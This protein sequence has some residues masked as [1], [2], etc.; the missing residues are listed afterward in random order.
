LTAAS[1]ERLLG[2]DF[3]AALGRVG[4]NPAELIQR[5]GGVVQYLDDHR[6]I[7]RSAQGLRLESSSAPL[8]VGG[9][10]RAKRPVELGLRRA[11]ASYVPRNPVT[12]LSI[13]D[14]SLGGAVLSTGVSLTFVGK[15]AEGRLLGAQ[16]VFFPEVAPS[17]DAVVTSQLTGADFA[18]VLRS[19]SAPQQIRYVVRL[20]A[21]S[22]LESDGLGAVV[23]SRANLVTTRILPP[24]SRDAQG[25]EIPT[26]LTVSGD[27]LL[28]TLHPRAQTYAYPILVDPEARTITESAEGWEFQPG[29]RCG[30]K[31]TAEVPGGGSPFTITAPTTT[32]PYFGTVACEEAEDEL[33]PKEGFPWQMGYLRWTPAASQP[34]NVAVYNINFSKSVSGEVLAEGEG[35]AL[36]IAIENTSNENCYYEYAAPIPYW[37][38]PETWT[39]SV[40]SN[41][42]C[43]EASDCFLQFNLTAGREKYT[44]ENTITVKA[45]VSAGPVVVSSPW[46]IP[47]E[48]ET[49]GEDWSK[50]AAPHVPKCNCGDPVDSLTGNESQTQMDLQ[51]G[52]RGPGLT[53]T[54]VYNSMLAASQGRILPADPGPTGYGWRMSYSAHMHVYPELGEATVSLDDGSTVDFTKLEEGSPWNPVGSLVQATLASSGENYVYTLP[55]Q[56]QLIFNGSGQLTSERD[57]NGNTVTISRNGEGLVSAATDDAGRKITFA[58]DA[59]GQLESATDPLGHTVT[60]GYEAGNL[61]S[62]TEPGEATPRWQFKYNAAHGITQET[63]GKGHSYSTEY[64]ASGRVSS[65]TD[66]LGR[67]R[68][69]SYFGKFGEDGEGAVIS[70][71]INEPNSAETVNEFNRSGLPL[72]ITRDAGTEEAS[73][74]YYSYDFDN[75]LVARTDPNGHK[76][77]FEYDSAGDKTG[78]TD[79]MGRT[80]HWEYDGRHDIVSVTEPSGEQ[81]TVERDG[82]GNATNISR[83]APESKTQ[84]T[85]YAYDEYGDLE[86]ETAPLE[87]TTHYAYDEYGDRESETDSEGNTRTWTYDK[88][89]REMSSVL[90][91]GNVEGGEPS[92]FTTTIE[93]DAQGRPVKVTE[94]EAG[95]VLEAGEGEA[96]GESPAYATLPSISG[97]AIEGRVLAA[98]AGT[99]E[100]DTPLAYT[101]QWQSCDS[102]GMSCLDIAGATIS[103]Y[104]PSAADVGQTLRVT[105]TA[106]NA[107]G[108]SSVSSAPTEPIDEGGVGWAYVSEFGSSGS[109]AGEFEHPGAIAADA[110][111]N[112]W[113]AD[114]Y[115]GRIEEFGAEGEFIKQFGSEGAEPGQFEFP[116]GIAADSE[117]DLWVL[118]TGNGRVQ[119]V[120]GEGEVLRTIGSFGFGTGQ[121]G[122]PEGI[123]LDGSGNVWVADTYHSRL[124]EF[125]GGGE[126]VKEIESSGTCAGDLVEP[127]G[128]AFDGSGNLWVADWSGHRLEELNASGECVAAIGGE[129]SPEVELENPYAVSIDP[130]GDVS[131]GSVEGDN[132]TE[133]SHE[134]AFLARF[135]VPGS[136]AG[137]LELGSP[138]GIAASASSVWVTDSAND[139][140]QLWRET[141]SPTELAAPRLSDEPLLGESA[142]ATVGRWLGAGPLSYTYQW[143]RCSEAGA[144]CSDLEGATSSTYTPSGGDVGSTLR[145]VV[146]ATNGSGSN[147]ANSAVSDVVGEPGAPS[148]TVAPT[149]AGELDVGRSLD[150]GAGSWAGAPAPSYTYQWRRCDAGGESCSNISGQTHA[151]YAVRHADIGSTLRVTVT[152]HNGLGS[153]A[154]ASSAT[155]VVP[156]PERSTLYRYDKNGNLEEATDPYGQATKYRYDEDNERTA[157]EE[158]DGSTSETEYGDLGLVTA[159]TNGGKY[160]TT[161]RHN[162]LG[163]VVETVD[164]LERAT[165]NT[166]DPAGNLETR[167][168]PAERVS[169][170]KYDADDELTSATYSDGTTPSVEYEYTTSGERSKMIDGTGTTTYGYDQ[171]G[172]LTSVEDG[173]GKTTEYGYD[174][175]NDMTK[176][177]YPNEKTVT[178]SF[179]S[180]GSLKSV[181]DWNEDTT[182]F[183][184]DPDS[185]LTTTTFPGETGDVDHYRYDDADLMAEVEMKKGSEVL[186]ATTYTRDENGLLT[187]TSSTGLPGEPEAVYRYNATGRMIKAGPGAYRYDAA[188]NLNK[189][190]GET[191]KYDAASELESG[192]GATYSY[193]DM[194]E[195]TESKPASGPAT[196]YEF[197]QAGNLITVKRAS[198]GEVSGIE[199]SFAYDG[200]GVRRTETIGGTSTDLTWNEAT[201]G[202]QLLSDG[203]DSFIYGPGGL[204][205]EQIDGEEHVLYLHHDEQGSTRLLTG[206]TGTVKGAN[207]FDPYGK[208]E[209]H[210]GSASTRLGYA[211]QY[212]DPDSGLIYLRARTYDPATAQFLSPDPLGNGIRE[213][214]AYGADDP[215]NEV[216]T[217]GRDAIPLP[218]EG[219]VAGP[220]AA[221]ACAAALTAGALLGREAVEN[222]YETASQAIFGGGETA[223]SDA[224]LECPL[225]RAVYEEREE[226]AAFAIVFAARDRNPSQDKKLSPGQLKKLKKAGYDPHHLKEGSHSDI[227]VGPDGQLYEKPIGG[228]GPG[229]DLGI[230][231]NEL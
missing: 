124:E 180:D 90:P 11:G 187:S 189:M 136:E 20:P 74:T 139:R 1:S 27:E 109:E 21:G 147:T 9:H 98:T 45:S 76:T 44:T 179:N 202:A 5:G 153:E 183:S 14:S 113:V 214:Y 91:R 97:S 117:G 227:Y 33:V 85:E 198:E 205:V 215:V 173:A 142:S 119:E 231:L 197:D 6:A 127:E 70:T 79:P 220:E 188:G 160:T 150:A 121:L 148:N 73:T 72:R 226:E 155:V 168:D 158:P 13:A 144:E 164:P 28:I 114:A 167:T 166:Y 54:R 122:F 63:D 105:V 165:V 216:D 169:T 221:A 192:A 195:R 62:V 163:E 78:E 67:K 15:A 96:G 213:A 191:L 207:T 29:E 110:S 143:Q 95:P 51:V 82:N 177:V 126:Y 156:A 66:P 48:S 30:P 123:A 190:D 209:A 182:S 152:A 36:C 31:F 26:D 42:T 185:D 103:S 94:P 10:G 132:V 131:V 224:A 23:L 8:R 60:Y 172:R 25:T 176:V 2:Q 38:P 222:A 199:D 50:L 204:P 146:T 64:D 128:L 59:E 112:L 129:G 52:G 106:K 141:A 159:Q 157:V 46:P 102:L 87:R 154:A 107:A 194:G 99:W 217:S 116:F 17:T 149:I 80:T 40:A 118:D 208:L 178:Q 56:L 34:F 175:A 84:T 133:F 219:C 83:P 135:G 81:T 170:Y 186:A 57:R 134:G 92:K 211:G 53:A 111:G 161:Y 19:A 125:T 35:A 218:V 86:T 137:E 55:N 65:Q 58:Y 77:T 104:T 210:T 61:V 69:W 130:T 145:V 228:A 200:D 12:S 7:V 75:H 37:P 100:G 22:R 49:Y 196:K 206:P 68:S 201:N 162:A 184:Y 71:R 115:T 39:G 138:V 120:N 24:R 151:A 108:E 230:N 229:E 4:V 89:S 171:L 43:I 88:D 140:V 174:L 203:A 212:T 18:A 225:A 41:N 223:E 93:R 47:D 16:S 3:G 193:D 181:T 101:Y 32:Y